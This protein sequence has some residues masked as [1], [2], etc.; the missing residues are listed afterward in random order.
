MAV[1]PRSDRRVRKAEKKWQAAIKIIIVHSKRHGNLAFLQHLVSVLDKS[2]SSPAKVDKKLLISS[3]W[4]DFILW[5]PRLIDGYETWY[6]QTAEIFPS[7][8]GQ[9]RNRKSGLTWQQRKSTLW[10]SQH[11]IN[12]SCSV[13]LI[14]TDLIFCFHFIV[15]HWITIKCVY[16]WTEL[17]NRQ[18]VCVNSDWPVI[19]HFT[20]DSPQTIS[21]RCICCNRFD[22]S[23]AARVQQKRVLK[24]MIWP[25]SAN[26]QYLWISAFSCRKK[27]QFFII[28][29]KMYS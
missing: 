20:T 5:V 12:V 4:S 13:S 9:Q 1:L 17:L 29:S 18:R 6:R 23:T 22:S 25:E 19:T 10:L 11:F 8:V 24:P 3:K 26:I 27:L 14:V 2:G 28:V 21:L 7:G 16:R 15:L